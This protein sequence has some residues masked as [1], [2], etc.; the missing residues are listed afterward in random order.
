MLFGGWGVPR[1]RKNER[2]LQEIRGRELMDGGAGV[3]RSQN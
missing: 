1:R 2:R 3:V